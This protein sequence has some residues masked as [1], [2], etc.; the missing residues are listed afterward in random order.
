MQ[1]TSLNLIQEEA[2]RIS[3]PNSAQFYEHL[4]DKYAQMK[5]SFSKTTDAVR[6]TAESLLCDLKAKE[7]KPFESQQLSG[8]LPTMKSTA[9]SEVN[10]L[11]QEHNR[12]T[13]EFSEQVA[14][15]REALEK[16][17]VAT[18]FS[19][20]RKYEEDLKS[21]NEAIKSSESKNAELDGEIADLERQIS[22]HRK[23]AEELN[24]DL[25]KYLGHDA[26]QLEILDYGYKIVRNGILAKALS[27]GEKTAIALLY[28][29]KSLEDERF[30]LENGVVVLD[31]PVSS[32]DSN[33][34][35]LAVAFIQ[36]RTKRAAQLILLTHNFTLFKLAKRWFINMNS[37]WDRDGDGTAA[38][39]ARF[40]MLDWEYVD[41]TRTAKMKP[42]DPLLEK[43]ESEYHFLFSQIYRASKDNRD[44]DLAEYYSL[45]NVARRLLEMFL[46]FRSPGATGDLPNQLNSAKLSSP[47]IGRIV[48][49]VHSHSHGDF[50]GESEHNLSMLSE[51]RQVMK[52][53]MALI[54]AEDKA[55][56]KAMRRLVEKAG[57]YA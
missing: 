37:E 28:F 39:P 10:L 19:E 57:A 42:L 34:L 52:D 30:E 54:R 38:K 51:G 13:E 45:A 11:I 2:E 14:Q 9:I 20:F 21:S 48:K 16:D 56:H 32:L 4:T 46:A 24:E 53:I 23:P 22:E 6:Q 18:V 26:I 8:G 49:F 31:D 5:E 36:E 40:Y 47:Q 41:G 1:V 29:L 33:A 12:L 55:H 3:L 35:Y 50:V 15:S 44:V 17:S 43:F 25:A 7:D 27:E